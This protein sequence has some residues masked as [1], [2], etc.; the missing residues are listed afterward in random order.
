M[1]TSFQANVEHATR[2]PV[3]V[4]SSQFAPP[5]WLHFWAWFTVLATFPLLTLGAEVTTKGVGMVDHEGYRHPWEVWTIWVREG[6]ENNR[7]DYFLEHSHRI[8]GFVVGSCVIVLM[9]GLWCT[10]KRTWLKWIGVVAL[11][12]VV[13]QGLLGIFRVDLNAT[14][15]RNLALVHGCT[16]QLVFGL[17]TTI[18]VCTAP[19]WWKPTQE[20]PENRPSRNR[21]RYVAIFTTIL[22]YSQ[23]VL[24]GFVRHSIMPGST[25]YLAGRLHI[26]GA[27]V[28]TGMIFWLMREAVGR[29]HL[30]RDVRVVAFL[31]GVLL[32]GQVALGTEAWLYKFQFDSMVQNGAVHVAAVQQSLLR[33]LHYVLGSA[34]FGTALALTVLT[35]RPTTVLSGRSLSPTVKACVEEVA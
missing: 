28:V 10:A 30:R 31:L 25:V 23:L 5:F 2:P 18:A 9:L 12:S 27:F 15:G 22:I 26:L 17:L 29:H 24:G 20:H 33:S 21:L 6:L 3:G 16:A 19:G 35:F 13:G 32:F 7:L 14:M 34:L 11:L 8:M 1:D 4:D